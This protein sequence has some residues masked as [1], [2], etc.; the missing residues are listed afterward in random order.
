MYP[1]VVQE[2]LLVDFVLLDYFVRDVWFASVGVLP[3]MWNR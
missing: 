3:S 1:I 2:G